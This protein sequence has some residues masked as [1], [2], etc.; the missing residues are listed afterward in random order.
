MRD[1]H[2]NSEFFS[3]GN[4]ASSYFPRTLLGRGDITYEVCDKAPTWIVRRVV[5][6]DGRTLHT[7]AAPMENVLHDNYGF[8]WSAA[9]FLAEWYPE[10]AAA[11]A[12]DLECSPYSWIT[13]RQMDDSELNS[14]LEWSECTRDEFEESRGSIFEDAAFTGHIVI[15]DC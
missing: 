5:S 8:D 6:G 9:E 14:M 1:F 4:S 7:S 10:F 11:I 13:I 3:N 15:G 12:E 2:I